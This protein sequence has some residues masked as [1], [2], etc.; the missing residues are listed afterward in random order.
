MPGGTWVTQNKVRP[1]VYINFVGEGKPTGALGE[2]GIVTMPLSLSW[3]PAKQIIRIDA[4]DNV[5]EVLGYDITAPELLL[6]REAL[7][8]AK[9]LLLYRLNTGSA[10][11]VTVG[12]LT[13]TAKYGGARGNDIKIIVQKNID[14]DAKFDVT[15]VFAGQAVEL[16][17]VKK[18]E[19][20]KANAFVEFSGSGDLEVTAGAPLTGGADGTTTN[21]DHTA[22]LE[23]IEVHD[24]HTMA[25]PS[26]DSSL[27]AVYVS[28]I[29]RLRD[30]EGVKVQLALE[31]YPTA[32]YEGVISVKNGVVLS[33]GVTLTA[34]QA[35]AWVAAATAAAN[36]NESL[37]YTAYDDAVDVDKRYTNSQIEAALIGGEL[38]FVANNGRAVVEQDINTFTSYTPEKGKQFGKNRVI[39]VLDSIGN[40]LKRIFERSYIGKVNN[41]DDGRSLLRAECTNYLNTLQ[42][43]AAIQNFD[44][45]TD[46]VVLPGT[47]V[48]SVYCELV[49]QPVDAIE[50]IYMKVKV[51]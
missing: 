13:A 27:K 35:T 41:N 10:A 28:F 7:K 18:V 21:Q 6:V 2:R 22:Y 24:F 39:R 14:D 11:K 16:Q 40:D 37:T 38:V 34:A 19:D 29:R 47:E 46:V 20:L 36:V 26:T 23:A 25:L 51:K 1:G 12:T 33:D 45:Q 44:P 15:T 49:V 50:K 30:K 31:N 43:I 5:S 9:T 42:A 4:G 17:V 3:G 8:R 32:D 48:D